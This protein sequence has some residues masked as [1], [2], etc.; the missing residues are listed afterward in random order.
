M[1]HMQEM[2]LKKTPTPV[3]WNVANAGLKA[4]L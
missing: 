2:G 1:L 3:F 4:T